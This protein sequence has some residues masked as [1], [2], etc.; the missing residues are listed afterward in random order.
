MSTVTGIVQEIQKKSVANGTKTAYNLVVAGESYGVGLY[1]PKCKVGDYVKFDVSEE[2]GYKD[3]ARG[4]LKVSTHKPPA[5]AV[6]QATQTAGKAAA[7]QDNKQETISRQSALNSAIAFMA[8]G[9]TLGTLPL[10]ASD[11]KG[12]KQEALDAILA[13]YT[14]AFY[15]QSTGQKWKGTA[16]KPVASEEAEPAEEENQDAEAEAAAAEDDGWR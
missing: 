11:A 15:E 1:A 16:A 4:S 5:E 9:A 13:K 8:V 2:R 3:V 12:K 10:P 6:A 7:T 14:Q